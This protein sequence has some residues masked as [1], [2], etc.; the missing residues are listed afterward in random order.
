[1]RVDAKLDVHEGHCHAVFQHPTL[2]GSYVCC[3]REGHDG[4]HDQRYWCQ[5]CQ[6]V[7]YNQGMALRHARYWHRR[8]AEWP[9]VEV[10]YEDRDLVR[11]AGGADE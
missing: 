3:D 8:G 1:M 5:H 10:G 7:L 6:I 11:Y 9:D 4:P 2:S